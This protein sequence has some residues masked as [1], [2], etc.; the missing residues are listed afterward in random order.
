MITSAN[1]SG[2][3][4]Q[5]P[6]TN[7]PPWAGSIYAC[8]VAAEGTRRREHGVEEVSSQRREHLCRL[9][10]RHGSPG[11]SIEADQTGVALSN[12][13]G[14][15]LGRLAINQGRRSRPP[16]PVSLNDKRCRRVGV[17]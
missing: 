9:G 1:L 10:D 4:G 3:A 5:A 13:T 16:D 12:A 11:S 8:P 7:G 14:G 17:G 2:Q 6:F 15:N